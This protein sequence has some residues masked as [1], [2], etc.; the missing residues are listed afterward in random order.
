MEYF[1]TPPLLVHLPHLV[2]EGEEFSHLTHVMRKTIGDAIRVVDGEGTMY[3]AVISEVVGRSARCTITSRQERVHESEIEVTLAAGIVKN[4]S[5]FDFL[6]EKATEIGVRTIVPLLTGR[7]VARHA[8]IDRWQKLALAAMKQSGRCI[9]PVVR[10][11][12][13]LADFL[14][15]AP[16]GGLRC[17]PHEQVV[18]PALRTLCG[19]SAMTSVILCI[20]P[21]GGFTH[22]EIDLATK[23][24]FVP[25]SLGPRRLRT[26][27][28]AIVA[29]ATV[30]LGDASRGA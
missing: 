13:P 18:T 30:L 7:S 15:A 21:E 9:L 6:V 24:G 27:T 3:E 20:G 12:T 19:Q 2:I 16:P 1:Y 25:V 22:E 17:I 11:L 10:P 23:E 5:N 28:A 26:E 8:R 29:A 14:R 4:A